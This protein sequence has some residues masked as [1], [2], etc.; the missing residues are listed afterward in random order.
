M[1]RGPISSSLF[2]CLEI[3][4]WSVRELLVQAFGRGKVEFLHIAVWFEQVLTFKLAPFSVALGVNVPSH[5]SIKCRLYHCLIPSSFASLS[6]TSPM[7]PLMSPSM[8]LETLCAMLLKNEPI[9]VAVGVGPEE[10]VA[11][12]RIL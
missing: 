5:K 11:V 9:E 3:S 12:E 2:S 7:I 8:V 1:W 6:A 10:V 4:K